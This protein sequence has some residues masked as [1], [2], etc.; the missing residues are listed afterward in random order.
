VCSMKSVDF[1]EV[2]LDECGLPRI[3]SSN[4]V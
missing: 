1:C 3:F 2:G 4:S